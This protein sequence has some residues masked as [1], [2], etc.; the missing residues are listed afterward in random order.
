MDVVASFVANTESA[1][2]V[3][4]ADGAFHNPAM[5][6]QA[7]AVPGVTFG[8]NRL[9]AA[10]SEASSMRFG[11]VRAVALHAVWF[12]P[13]ATRLTA[14]GG[15]R[16]HQGFELRDVVRVGAGQRG[17]EWNAVGVG[18]Q[19]MFAASFAA[20]RGVSAR[21]FPPCTARTEDESTIAR[22][23]SINSASCR[24]AS[25]AACKFFHTPRFCQAR[26][27]FA[28]IVR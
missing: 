23:Q 24:C 4:P 18:D 21:F 20:I 25:N 9:N 8:E 27:P 5:L 13:R 2:L 15:N 22:D 3:Q 28:Q 1:E 11:I 6:A 16:F 17:G 19:M 14:H 12:A 26:K 7:A 10:F